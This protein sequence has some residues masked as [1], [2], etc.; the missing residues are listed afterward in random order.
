MADG[1]STHQRL[2]GTPAFTAPELVSG[3]AADPFAAD[4]WALGACL[5]CFIYGQLPFQ[6]GSVMDVFKAIASTELELPE[7]I[8]ISYS[9]RDL[10]SRL[11]DKNPETRIPLQVSQPSWAS[12]CPHGGCWLQCS[13]CGCSTPGFLPHSHRVCCCLFVPVGARFFAAARCLHKGLALAGRTCMRNK[14]CGESS[15]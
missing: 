6:G 14:W 3:N 4:V 13:G 10:F 11:F 1:K 2:T 15:A 8:K 7:D 12:C 9:L 5:F